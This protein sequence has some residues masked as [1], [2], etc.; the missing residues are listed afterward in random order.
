VTLRAKTIA[1]FLTTAYTVVILLMATNCDSSRREEKLT[2]IN[3]PSGEEFAGSKTCVQC[4]RSISQ[5]FSETPHFLTS[6]A[7]SVETVE[8]SLDS[9]ENVLVLTER[10]KVFMEERQGTVFQRA[11]ID[12]KDVDK[13][14]MDISVGSGRQGQTYLYWKSDSLFQLPASYHAATDTW[15]NSP[16]YPSDRIIFDR[17]ISARCLECHATNFKVTKSFGDVETFD[18]SKAILG[19][20]CERCHGPAARHVNFHR[21]NSGEDKGRFIVN[22]QALDKKL[23]IDN[24]AL[25]HSGMRT[26]L[27]PSFSYRVGNDLDHFFVPMQSIDSGASVDVH[28]NQ[29]GLLRA[30]KCF[31]LSEMDCSTCHDVHAKETKKL[32]LFS[33]RCMNCHKEGS[34]KF[35]KQPVVAGIVL[36]DNC[37]DCHMPSLPSSKVFLQSASRSDPTPFFVRTHLISTYRKQ[38]DIFIKNAEKKISQTNP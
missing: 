13:R 5:S 36:R 22:P 4:H 11:T 1:F 16:G 3:H 37:V 10:L 33:A 14:P 27:M 18:P 32:S 19:V 25:C 31:K 17:S 21:K 28:G 8:G 38:I 12:G 6:S 35:C 29:V 2:G 15:S 26:N 9:G 23:R 24:C 20:D 34:D 7:G 30:S